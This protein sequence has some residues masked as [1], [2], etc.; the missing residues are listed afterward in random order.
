MNWSG[1]YNPLRLA[2]HR[3]LPPMRGDAYAVLVGRTDAD[4]N[5]VDG[6]RHPN[7][8]A[9][10]GTFTGW[11]LRREGFAEGAQCR[12]TGSFIPFAATRAERRSS[13]DPRPS[14]EERYPDHA[15]YVRAVGEAAEALV[16]D[17]LLLPEDADEIVSRARRSR[18]RTA[19]TV[20][21]ASAP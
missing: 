12:G 20:Q 19:G 13:G 16:E 8:V 14:L 9:P 7:L 2:D 15:A 6:V 1:S 17:R 18:D 3:S 21:Q 11:N 10:L 5:M 4:G